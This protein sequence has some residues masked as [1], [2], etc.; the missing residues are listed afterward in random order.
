MITNEAVIE[1]KECLIECW[2]E[3]GKKVIAECAKV[4]P[5]D[6]HFKDFLDHCT[7]CAEIGAE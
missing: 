1:T 6:R 7:A 2:G 3:D 5:F 4:T